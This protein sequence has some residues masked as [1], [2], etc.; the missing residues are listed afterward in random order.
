M[1]EVLSKMAK[2]TF[3]TLLVLG[4]V[5]MGGQAFAVVGAND[6]VPA[7]TLLLPYFEVDLNNANGVTTLF[8]VN[9]ASAAP[10]LAHITI[11]TDMTVPILD[12]DVYLTGYD[13]QSF[14]LRDILVGGIL[15]QTGS[16]IS[17]NGD[18]SL[19]NSNF[20]GCN[21]GPAT[22]APVYSPLPATVVGI[23]QDALTGVALRAGQAQG[24]CA[25]VPYGDGIA[26][27]YIT[28][29]SVSACSTEVPSTPGYF[30]NGGLGT[31][32]NN[33]VLW[34][35]YFYVDVANAFAQGETL[36]HIEAGGGLGVGD[37]T[38]YARYSGGED[39][40]EGLASTFASRYVVDFGGLPGGTDLVVWRDA[41]LAVSFFA[42]GTLPLPYPM[43]QNQIV[44]FDE[45]E[46]PEVP[47]TSPFSP[48][49]GQDVLIP[50]PWEANRTT[51]GGPDFPVN[52]DAGWLY[53]NLNTATG[54]L[55][56]FDPLTQNW[57][58]TVMSAD[59]L[60]SAGFDAI[61]LD[62]VSTNPT[63]IIL[64]VLP[65]ATE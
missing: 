32:N 46:N 7:A 23:I 1:K 61:Q 55:P 11:W 59:G 18:F 27:G 10:A 8:S 65:V 28:V 62:N 51:V 47:E 33:N 49:I 14:N 36:V 3:V 64:P 38:F 9:N 63:D 58:T 21:T 24:L 42:C 52:P 41:K 45:E 19:P 26:R 54:G 5:A 25:G 15:P 17:N 60:F 40:R 22:G 16:A 39:N 34:G 57:V 35:D 29:D 50:F 4:L 44:I 43:S 53:L 37:Y 31:A 56:A 6:N 12:F 13:V 48:P 30:V 2:K 20:P